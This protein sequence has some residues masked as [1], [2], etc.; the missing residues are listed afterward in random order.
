MLLK[1]ELD[2][3]GVRPKI[4]VSK[5]LIESGGQAF[6]RGALYTLLRNPIYVGAS[7]FNEGG[8]KDHE[9]ASAAAVS[10]RKL[11]LPA[12]RTPPRLRRDSNA[13]NVQGVLMAPAFIS[14][15]RVPDGAAI[16]NYARCGE[17]GTACQLLMPSG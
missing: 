2:R 8:R 9:R 12:R 16:G 5:D 3:N 14:F 17:P 7:C 15:G 10:V 11:W 4:R 1:E 13:F 6:S